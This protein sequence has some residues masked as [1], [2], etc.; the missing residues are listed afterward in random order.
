MR[1]VTNVTVNAFLSRKSVKM[2]NTVSDGITLKLHGNVI[3]EW[4]GNS[5]WVTLAGWPTVTTRE[6]LNGLC[7]ELGLT[8]FYQRK[9]EQFFN[10][11]PVGALEWFKLN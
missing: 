8:G 4:R 2:G 7:D 5:V 11:R 6:R 1:K 3:A 9:G 10:G